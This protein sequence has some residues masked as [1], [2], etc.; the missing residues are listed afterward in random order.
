MVSWWC[1]CCPQGTWNHIIRFS[2]NPALC[3]FDCHRYR[4][5]AN[6]V[7]RQACLFVWPHKVVSCSWQAQWLL[8]SLSWP[9]Y[10]AP[11]FL[12][13]HVCVDQCWC[14]R[15]LPH[16][17]CCLLLLVSESWRNEV[18]CVCIVG[19]GGGGRNAFHVSKNHTHTCA[20]THTHTG[21]ILYA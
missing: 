3:P 8:V 20:C 10:R 11:V 7:P 6:R 2:A 5:A 15:L 16:L 12:C 4:P 21:L 13:L 1:V 17:V 9:A 14:S 18:E 19:G